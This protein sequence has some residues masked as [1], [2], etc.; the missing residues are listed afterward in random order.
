MSGIDEASLAAVQGFYDAFVD[1][2][3]PVGDAREA[4]LAKLL[5]N[6]FRHVNIA[7]VNEMAM[8]ANDLGIDMWEVVDA[9]ATKPFGF[10][11]FNPGPGVGGHC[12]P[13]DPSYLSWRVRALA[14]PC[15]PFRRAGQRHQ[16]AH[17]GLC[18]PPARVRVQPPW[19]G[20]AGPARAGAR[21]GVQEEHRRRPRVPFARGRR[22]Y[23]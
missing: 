14:R 8:F 3:V 1:I 7:L 18:A 15:V 11:R 9:A 10:M 22:S 5:E 20:R 2:T 21:V 17:A 19:R 13:I 12:L 23:W 4:E 16:P 6:T